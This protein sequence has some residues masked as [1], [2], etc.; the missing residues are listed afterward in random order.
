MITSP[1]HDG[2][3]LPAFFVDSRGCWIWTRRT[4]YGYAE[5]QIGGKHFR[6]ARLHW[7]TFNGPIPAGLVIDHL[8]RV[9]S[10]VNPAH[11]EVVTEQ[12]NILRGVSGS[13]INAKKTHCPK[14]HLYD[15]FTFYGGRRQR[16]CRTCR[17]Q[18]D[19]NRRARK[20]VSHG[21]S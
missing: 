12:V 7:E 19:L 3:R 4:N 2:N 14:G 6:I 16:F 17:N 10:C 13:A 9:R 11:L 18:S 15:L 20:R 5:G 8:C 21:D 1:F